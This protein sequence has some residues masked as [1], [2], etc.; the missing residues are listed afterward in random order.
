MSKSTKRMQIAQTVI[1]FLKFRM[2]KPKMA[3]KMADK[4]AAYMVENISDVKQAF[5]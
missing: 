1:N 2:N 5:L 3:A 4:M